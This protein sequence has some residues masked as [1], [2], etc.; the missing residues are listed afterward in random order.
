VCVLVAWAGGRGWL[1][2]RLET[3][4]ALLAPAALGLALAAAL[5]AA[6]F[7]VDLPGYRFGWRQVASLA[8]GAG[9]AAG[10]LPVLGGVPDGQWSLTN[11][12]VARS[13]AWLGP[14]AR[15]G[16]F[17]VLWVGNP[18]ALP[19]DSWRMGEGL[20]FATSRDG[21]PEATD[22]LPGSA[23]GATRSIGSA[24]E[25]AERGDTARLGRLL[26][27]MAIRYIVVPVELATGRSNPGRY[28]A[29]PQ[30]T[31]AL[32]S[33]IDLRLLPSDPGV[34]VYENTSWGPGREVL[35]GRLAG[36]VPA[37]LGAGADL[38]G[39]TPVLPGRGPTE[40]RGAIPNDNT[41][42]VA[43]APSSR[44]AL[45]VGG[46]KAVR[47]TAFGVANA[48]RTGGAGHGVL[49]Y[50]TPLV[51]YALLLLQLVL[52]VVAVRALLRLRRRAIE[53]EGASSR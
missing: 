20:A 28:P 7:D 18:A 25:V 26:A 33:Q 10:V 34:A 52:W 29:P 48:Y 12:E 53:V 30:L 41:V 46:S 42:F 38:S 14:Q 17:R 39:G 31:R 47:Q 6:A 44:W 32:V 23:S 24:I 13:L 22:L 9:I 36:P 43:E 27:P 4:D 16:S 11:E 8:A 21:T 19:L 15:Q 49:R 35:P 5:G 40:F 37:Q 51:R 2:L 45:S 50:H 3:P 1:P